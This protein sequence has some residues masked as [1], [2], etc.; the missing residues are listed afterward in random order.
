MSDHANLLLLCCFLCVQFLLCVFTYTFLSSSLRLNDLFLLCL[1]DPTA[2]ISSD[3]LCLSYSNKR[4]REGFRHNANC[5]NFKWLEKASF[6]LKS[7]LLNTWRNGGRVLQ[8]W[9]HLTA[10]NCKSGGF[11]TYLEVESGLQLYFQLP[12]LKMQSYEIMRKDGNGKRL[13]CS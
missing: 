13:E 3:S 11:P 10:S 12:S 1:Y 9:Q 5:S 2:L 6:S 7:V 4:V 8:N